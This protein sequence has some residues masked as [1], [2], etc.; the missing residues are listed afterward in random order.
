MGVTG[1]KSRCHPSCIPFGGS[2]GESIPLSFLASRG[3][4]YS[5]A[6]GPLLV[7][8]SFQP[9]LPMITSPSLI[10]TLLHLY[11]RTPVIILSLSYNSDSFPHIKTI[12]SARFFVPG[13]VTFMYLGELQ[14]RYLK[15]YLSTYHSYTDQHFSIRDLKTQ[16]IQRI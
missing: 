10:L 4:L 11:Y 1:L 14:H 6:C 3:H 15:G 2:R 12:P 9:L 5:L 8:T 13:K 7:I 16:R